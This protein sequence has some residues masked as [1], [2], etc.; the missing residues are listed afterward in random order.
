MDNR[1]NS[2]VVVY[3]PDSQLHTPGL[4]LRSMVKDLLASRELA[5]RLFVRD[6]SGQYRQSM[7]GFVWAFIPPIITS[8]IFIAL[9]SRNVV[10]FGQ[11]DI[12]YPVYV[13]VGTLLWQVFTDSLNA[14]LKAVT[15]ARPMLVRI[16]FPRESLVLS[17]IY[18]VFY[19]LLIKLIVLA[20]IFLIF[21]LELTWG[22]LLAMFP[23][24]MLVVLGIAVGLF[25]T[26]LGLLYTDVATSLPIIIQVFFFVTPVVYPPPQMFPF[27]LLAI[28]N[29]VS[30]ILIAARD[31]LT[32]GTLSNLGPLLVISGL[33]FVLLFFAWTIYRVALPIIIERMSS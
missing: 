23:I 1:D 5:W 29:P 25:L 21:R 6:L 2:P 13:L 17:S 4:L 19:N 33:T 15:A 20:V 11:T 16:N 9:Q 18:L 10:N 7:L 12:P 24:L 27:S 3:T 32:K 22:V 31:L 30:P 28:I 14:P 8:L 26:P